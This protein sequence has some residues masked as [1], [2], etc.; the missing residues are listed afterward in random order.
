MQ[1]TRES[2]ELYDALLKQL[3]EA[4]LTARDLFTFE[5][6]KE[7]SEEG[8][9]NGTTAKEHLEDMYREAMNDPQEF[10][11]GLHDDAIEQ[12]NWWF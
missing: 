12:L 6:A 2:H 7:A 10:I 8:P 3:N 1:N 9:N 4:G 5:L 11:G